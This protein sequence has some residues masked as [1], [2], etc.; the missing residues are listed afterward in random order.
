[1]GDLK[2][3]EKWQRE[4]GKL[5]KEDEEERVRKEDIQQSNLDDKKIVDSYQHPKRKQDGDEQDVQIRPTKDRV[6]DEK[7]VS[8]RYV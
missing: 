2:E 8:G 5:R 3:E 4:K 6:G 1:M 7:K